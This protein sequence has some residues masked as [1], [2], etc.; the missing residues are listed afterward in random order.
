MAPRSRTLRAALA[1]VLGFAAILVFAASAGA[2]AKAGESAEPLVEGH[3]AGGATAVRAS[4]SYESTAGAVV[5]R[6][7]FV[8]EPQEGS[9]ADVEAMLFAAPAGCSIFSP[10]EGAAEPFLRVGDEYEEPTS[11]EFGEEGV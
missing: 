1:V 8:A 5:F 10:P 7:T 4:A 2:E 9:E 11:T 3:P 6:L